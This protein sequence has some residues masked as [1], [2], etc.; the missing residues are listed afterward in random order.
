MSRSS[1]GPPAG[2]E[3]ERAPLQ[4]RLDRPREVVV[5]ARER[6]VGRRVGVVDRVDLV[7]AH[8]ALARVELPAEERVDQAADRQHLV[9]ELAA[10]GSRARPRSGRAW[11]ARGGTS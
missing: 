11:A 6:D 9:A 5:Q 4:Q 1:R 8:Q 7:A 2:D 10:T 3:A